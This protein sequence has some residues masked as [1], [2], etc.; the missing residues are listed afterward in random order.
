MLF[1]Q[2]AAQIHAQIPI[3]FVPPVKVNVVAGI[4]RRF[5]ETIEL[6]RC[7]RQDRYLKINSTAV[8][9]VDDYTIVHCAERI[10]SS[11]LYRAI[12]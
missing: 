10:R 7:R 12:Q 8:L 3:R 11:R 4:E 6:S 2:V 5:G 1:A 9:A